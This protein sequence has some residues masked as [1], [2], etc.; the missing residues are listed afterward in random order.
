MNSSSILKK[1]VTFTAKHLRWSPFYTKVVNLSA[2]ATA[3]DFII[4]CLD[5]LTW[6][7]L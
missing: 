7:L 5:T 6:V 2:R 1:F 3:S 4:R